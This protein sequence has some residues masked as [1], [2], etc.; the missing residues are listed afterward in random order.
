MHK[1]TGVLLP[2]TVGAN[3]VMDTDF[4][5]W[6]GVNRLKIGYYWGGLTPP[7]QHYYGGG[8]TPAQAQNDHYYYYYGG[9]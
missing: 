5:Y 3:R 9:G 4:H 8:L 1:Y 2:S 6:G 7:P